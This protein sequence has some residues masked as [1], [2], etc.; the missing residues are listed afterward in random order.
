MKRVAEFRPGF[1]DR[2]YERG[3]ALGAPIS[4]QREPDSPPQFDNGE[5]RQ[6]SSRSEA[7]FSVIN[8]SVTIRLTV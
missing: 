6:T 4:I 3:E 7:D 1:S 8:L 5:Y 2:L